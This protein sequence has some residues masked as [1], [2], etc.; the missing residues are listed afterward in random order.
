MLDSSLGYWH[1]FYVH[2]G[3]IPTCTYYGRLNSTKKQGLPV[4]AAVF[5][6]HKDSLTSACWLS[7]HA[8]VVLKP[9]S[10]HSTMAGI[11]L[12]LHKSFQPRLKSFYMPCP[13][14]GCFLT[15]LHSTVSVR[16]CPCECVCRESATKRL[17]LTWKLKL[18]PLFYLQMC[19]RRRFKMLKN[20]ILFFPYG[21]NEACSLLFKEYLVSK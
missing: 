17:R 6:P 15:W 3:C 1:W 20:V 14:H 16:V 19:F 8:F 21:P 7:K 4:I 2:I 10:K 12:P 9:W 5:F 13:V 18:A 11:F